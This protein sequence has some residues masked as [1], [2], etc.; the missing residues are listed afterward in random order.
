MSKV[1]TWARVPSP[2]GFRVPSPMPLM[3]PLLSAQATPSRYQS[4]LFKSLNWF[5]RASFLGLGHAAGGLAGGGTA[6][7]AA[8]AAAAAGPA[9]AAVAGLRGEPAQ[10]AVAAQ[11]G[12]G[13]ALQL[14]QDVRDTVGRF[15]GAFACSVYVG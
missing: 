1:A 13:Q 7:A 15:H 6:T 8:A 9:A 11:G 2:P 12:R 3:M 10:E 14:A 4:P 5:S